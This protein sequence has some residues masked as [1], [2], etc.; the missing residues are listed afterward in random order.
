MI[1]INYPDRYQLWL[2]HDL[3]NFRPKFYSSLQ[4]E[5]QLSIWQFIERNYLLKFEHMF[6]IEFE[7]DSDAIWRIPFPGSVAIGP[8]YGHDFF[9]LPPSLA[10]QFKKWRKNIDS[11][12]EPWPKGRP[13]DMDVANKIG[14]VIA[15]QIKAHIGADT[16]LEFNPF[17]ELII[18]GDKVIELP[19][20]DFVKIA[21]SAK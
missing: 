5:D 20:P 3:A 10:Q 19:E 1:T 13:F 18:D 2:D 7:W 15:M 9:N 14:L 21:N 17:R 6:R 16:Y 4:I 12:Y 11:N 8:S